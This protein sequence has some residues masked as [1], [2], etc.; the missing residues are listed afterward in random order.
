MNKLAKILLAASCLLPASA[1]L[2]GPT[3]KSFQIHN[4]MNA[5]L[6]WNNGPRNFDQ[7]GAGL[8]NLSSHYLPSAEGGPRVV[9]IGTGSY[10]DIPDSPIPQGTRLQAL[11]TSWKVDETAGLVKDTTR[12]ITANHGNEYQ[13]AM[14]PGATP[15]MNGQYLFVTYGYDRNGNTETYGKVI[16]P[17]CEELSDQTLIIAKNNDDVAGNADL[18]HTLLTDG[19]EE[20]RLGDCVIGN[21]NGGDNMYCYGVTVT[22]VGSQFTIKKDFDFVGEAEEERSRSYTAP[23]P[24]MPGYMFECAA[25]G[26]NQPPDRGLRCGLMNMNPG[27]ANN[28]RIVW[29]KYLAERDGNTYYTVPNLAAVKGSDGRTAF[30]VTYVKVVTNG[31]NNR[32]QT[33]FMQQLVRPSETGLEILTPPSTDLVPVGDKSHPTMCHGSWG[34]DDTPAAFVVTGTITDGGSGA[35]SILRANPDVGEMHN[36]G[37]H[38]NAITFSSS[39]GSGHISQMYGNNPNTPQ[40]RNHQYCEML[41][42]P[43]YQKANGFQPDVKAFLMLSNTGHHAGED[44][45][46]GEVVLVPAVVPAAANPVDPEPTNPDPDPVPTPTPDPDPSG[47]SM[48]GCSTGG[49]G[50]GAGGA[51]ILALGAAVAGIRRRRR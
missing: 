5:G 4:G 49:A 48:G 15:I 27:V 43:G 37:G 23:V 11:C 2:A 36:A 47:T 22:K 20:A 44:K 6:L 24:E 45:S 42:N 18:T 31:R 21:G 32:G 14:I 39:T 26:D 38:G 30:V 1:A 28:Q 41:P 16:G 33:Q 9:S 34:E 25:V 10:T 51:L 46:F 50:G 8:E 13:N 19:P 35:L 40:G 3:V 17:N 12:Y 29:R 7:R